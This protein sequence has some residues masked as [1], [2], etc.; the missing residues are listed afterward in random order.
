MYPRTIRIRLVLFILVETI[1][2]AVLHKPYK[3]VYVLITRTVY[4]YFFSMGVLHREDPKVIH[5]HLQVAERLSRPEK[6]PSK[7]RDVTTMSPFVILTC[8]VFSIRLL[9]REN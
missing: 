6:N 2:G 5:C 3:V 4:I 1:Q 8:D 7:T 9:F